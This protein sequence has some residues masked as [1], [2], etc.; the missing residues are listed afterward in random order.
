MSSE[1]IEIKSITSS[2][3][4]SI[5]SLAR[6]NEPTPYQNAEKIATSI[7]KSEIRP[8]CTALGT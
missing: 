5:P 8:P 1:L 4:Y 6:K 2:I 3:C 7:L